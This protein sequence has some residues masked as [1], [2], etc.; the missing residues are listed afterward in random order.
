MQET[1]NQR[2]KFLIEKLGLSVRGFSAA[3]DTPVST[4]RN[5]LDKE[6]KPSTDY[7]ERISEHFKT[8]NIHWLITGQGEPFIGEAPT[9]HT[10]TRIKKVTGG[11]INSGSGDQLVTLESCQRELEAVKRDAASYQREIELLKG[12]LESKDALIAA[13]DEM[14]NFLRGGYNRPN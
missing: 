3:L 10:S 4:T 7:I 1:I 9:Q 2:I 12:Q 13:K 8:V 14:L 5:Y 11:A 6:T